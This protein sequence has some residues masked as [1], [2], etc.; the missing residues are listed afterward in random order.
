[1]NRYVPEFETQPHK[2]I[3]GVLIFS[4]YDN[5]AADPGIECGT[6]TFPQ[7]PSEI[8][9]AGAGQMFFFFRRGRG[10][11]DE[12]QPPARD[13]QPKKT[14]PGDEYLFK[15]VS[16]KYKEITGIQSAHSKK[17]AGSMLEWAYFQFGVPSFSANLWSLREETKGPSAKMPG[18]SSASSQE[19]T[20]PAAG[21]DRRAMFMQMMAQ[22]GGSAPGAAA[23]GEADADTDKKWLEWIDQKNNGEGFVD[24]T[25]FQHQQLGEVEIGGFKPYLRV[26][27]PED[28]IPELVQSHSEFALFMASQFAEI[29][30][31]KPQVKKLASG[32]FELKVTL[33]NKGGFPYVTAMGQ[34]TRTISPIMVKLTFE[35]DERMT[36][37]GGTQRV[38]T[39]NI[40]PGGE[41]ELTWLI[42]SPSGK[43]VNI[44]LWARNGGGETKESVFLR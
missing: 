16:E 11:E 14:L 39:T 8:R 10:D 9:S 26:N 34:R 40:Q 3:C 31:D 22:R 13:P 20:Q 12:Q 28:K 29:V 18:A 21:S 4:K 24:W 5:L 41:K 44:R 19:Q 33:H 36:L 17:P 25:P 37:F 32:F 6:P 27:P 7:P 35:D 30:M 38:D 23:S 42:L 1:M 2:N 15:N 43:N